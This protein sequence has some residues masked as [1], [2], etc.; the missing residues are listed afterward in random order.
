MHPS[1]GRVLT[2]LAEAGMEL[3][4][5]AARDAV[6][7][8]L[9]TARTASVEAESDDDEG[10]RTGTDARADANG[11]DMGDGEAS[12]PAPPRRAAAPRTESADAAAWPGLTRTVGRAAST[13]A[14]PLPTAAALPEA[15][16]IARG[17]R[18][19]RRRVPSASGMDLDVEATVRRAAEEDIWLPVLR[20]RRER[21][22][23]LALV[24]DDSPSMRVWGDVVDEFARVL[25][26]SGAFRSITRWHMRD[27]GGPGILPHRSARSVNERP[28]VPVSLTALPR[29]G[30]ILVVSDLVADAWYDASHLTMLA[31][32][33]HAAPVAIVQVLPPQLWARTALARGMAVQLHAPSLVATN[34]HLSASAPAWLAPDEEEARTEPDTFVAPVTALTPDAI[35]QLARLLGGPAT[36]S[37]PG[38]A[39]DL[40]AM[41]DLGPPPPPRAM[42]AAERVRRFW[43][44]ASSPARRLAS[45]FA[46]SPFLDL[47]VLRLLRREL[48]PGGTH[49]HEAEVVLG[50]IL[51]RVEEEEVV[52]DGIAFRFTEGVRPLLLDNIATDD[53][54]RVLRRAAELAATDQADAHLFLT[55]L[56]DPAGVTTPL[57]RTEGSFTDR[58]AGFLEWLGGPYARMVAGSPADADAELESGAEQAPFDGEAPFEGQAPLEGQA[59]FEPEAASHAEASAEGEESVT[60]DDRA[61]DPDATFAELLAALGAMGEE[62]ALELAARTARAAEGERRP[63]RSAKMRAARAVLLFHMGRHEEAELEFRSA[64]QR[65]RDVH[66]LSRRSPALVSAGQAAIEIGDLWTAIELLQDALRPLEATQDWAGG[67]EALQLLAR[68]HERREEYQPAID[69]LR[70]AAD[71][72]QRNGDATSRALTLLERV[73]VA[74]RGDAELAHSVPA[75]A[76]EAAEALRNAQVDVHEESL[77]RVLQAMQRRRPDG[78]VPRVALFGHIRDGQ[79]GERLARALDV[80]ARPGAIVVDDFVGLGTDGRTWRPGSVERMRGADLVI[81]VLSQSLL[82]DPESAR[83]AEDLATRVNLPVAPVLVEPTE[84]EK[85]PWLAR[86]QISPSS[87]R[88]LNREAPDRLADVIGEMIGTLTD[89]A[90][91]REL[92]RAAGTRNPLVRLNL[93]D[94]K[95]EPGPPIDRALATLEEAWQMRSHS[96]VVVRG[97]SGA[98]KT[99]LV[100][101]WLDRLRDTDYAGA[102]VVL[103]WSFYTDVDLSDR[104]GAFDRFLSAALD[105]LAVGIA[106]PPAEKARR[107]CRELDRYR[108]L[109]VLDG[110]EKVFG[111]G[112]GSGRGYRQ[113]VAV[114]SRG[115]AGSVA[116]PEAFIALITALLDTPGAMTVMTTTDWSDRVVSAPRRPRKQ[117]VAPTEFDLPRDRIRLIELHADVPPA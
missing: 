19:L 92:G 2:S 94:A 95:I 60:A 41:R 97:P 6:W 76:K 78:Y 91:R 48:I 67:A 100:N 105:W 14:I 85:L 99:G 70:L 8:A 47:G 81:L 79:W 103:G 80:F 10:Q 40:V 39:F 108:S 57:E 49:L 18:P 30:L 61:V 71:M 69:R 98:G 115:D 106:A 53:A 96:I 55:A 63:D 27:D 93:L 73:R 1:L 13:H 102:D 82:N 87:D 36:D 52:G 16:W 114:P 113:S 45:A 72:W 86:L 31:R 11:V 51:R 29:R 34:A 25:R 35:G 50:G 43:S 37:T 5:E 65:A 75:L 117:D 83:A 23:D 24:V 68:V 111:S 46:A 3:D 15:R 88:P 54:L 89:L 44:V 7:L 33:S 90:I 107:L 74:L 101:A 66:D 17:L 112:D 9:R 104:D 56:D 26:W 4:A 64:A 12:R 28:R 22:L 38:Y 59:P 116:L 62:Q 110:I 32:W 42:P 21:W 77:M 84:W 109:V 58:V 20:S